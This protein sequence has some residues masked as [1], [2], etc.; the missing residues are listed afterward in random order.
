MK[1]L[2]K[3]ARLCS[4]ITVLG[5]L[6]GAAL[7]VAAAE[8]D[9]L[10]YTGAVQSNEAPSA[11]FSGFNS[12]VVTVGVRGSYYANIQEALDRINAIRLEACREGVRNPANPSRN[13]TINDYRPLK[14]SATLEKVARQRAAEASLRRGHVRPDGRS[15]E[16]ADI[17]NLTSS[18]ELIAWSSS[19]NLVDN[20]NLFYDEKNAWVYQTG[21]KSGHYAGLI[22]PNNTYVGLGGFY[23]PEC[24]SY[25]GSMCARLTYATDAGSTSYGQPTDTVMVSIR[26]LSSYLST[27]KISESSD[28]SDKL[29]LGSSKVYDMWSST[30]IDEMSG[31]VFFIDSLSWSS[32]NTDVARV[33]GGR[34]TTLSMGKAT[35]TAASTTGVSASLYLEVTPPDVSVTLNKSKLNLEPGQSFQL[36]TTL[37]P[38]N[39]P[40]NSITWKNSDSTVVSLTSDGKVTAKKA[41]TA[42]ITAKAM[43]GDTAKCTVVVT[44]PP[45]SITLDKTSKVLGVG[46]T[47]QL[48]ATLPSDSTPGIT[49]TTGNSSVVTVSNGKLT[50]KGVGTTTVTA[51]TTNGKTAVCNVEVKAAPPALLMSYSTKPI[52]LGETF[53]LTASVP[54]GCASDSITW[55][56]NNSKVVSVTNGKIKGLQLGSATITAKTYNGR[57][58]T[59][60]VRVREAPTSLSLDASSKKIGV[61]EKVTLTAILNKSEASGKI[62]WTSADKSVVTVSGGVV[63]GVGEGTAVV[64]AATFN[65]KTARCTVTVKSAPSSIALNKSSATLGV[66]EGL[67]LKATLSSGSASDSIVWSSSD[68]SVAAVENGNVTPLKAGTAVISAKTYNGKIARCSITVKNAPEE[69]TLSESKIILG[70]GEAASLDYSIPQDSA[71]AVRWITSNS[72]TASVNGGRITA[73][74]EGTAT[75]T[76]KTYNGKKASCGIVVRSAPEELTI[77]ETS[78]TVGMGEIRELSAAVNKGSASAITWSSSNS[79][80]ASVNNGLVFSI[81]TGTVTITAETYNGLKASCTIEVVSAPEEITLSRNSLVLGMGE[82]YTLEATIPEGSASE[83]R[84]TSSNENVVTVKDGKITTVGEGT[85]D[86]TVTAF[87]G[88]SDSCSITVR[89]APEWITL[90]HEKIYLGVGET[91]LLCAQIPEESASAITWKTSNPDIAEVEDGYVRA[92]TE[93]VATVTVKTYNGQVARCTVVVRSAPQSI[94]LSEE[95]KDI[96]EGEVYTLTASVPK[97]TASASIEWI[98][99]DESVASVENGVVTGLGVGTAVIG[100]RTYNGMMDRCVINVKA[101]PQSFELSEQKIIIGEGESFLLDTVFAEGTASGTVKWTSSTKKTAS[102]TDGLVQ[103]MSTGT[104]RITVT[105]YNGIKSTCSVI[106]RA[107]PEEVSLDTDKIYIGVGESYKLTATLPKGSISAL[108]WRAGNIDIASVENGTI[109]GNTE[110]VTTVTVKTFNGMEARCT[111]VVRAEPYEISLNETKKTLGVGESVTLRAELPKGTASAGLR[112][113]SGN[114]SV[115]KVLSDG[116]VQAVGTGSTVIAVRTYNGLRAALKLTVR[117]APQSITLNRTKK[118]LGIGEKYQLKTTLSKGSASDTIIWESS[119]NEVVTVENGMLTAVGNGTAVVSAATFNGMTATCKVIVKNAP[120]YVALDNEE[121]TLYEGETATLKASVT[122]GSFSAYIWSVGN[123]AIASVSNGTVKALSAGRTR[124][125]VKTYNGL[126]TT[127]LVIV[128]AAA[129]DTSTQ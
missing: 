7:S 9:P 38:K 23:S 42:V 124:V 32:S 11:S 1:I 79:R 12:T 107:A 21:E 114:I 57:T 118:Y 49:W 76:V 71:S 95:R 84:W 103:G 50:A 45:S 72:E 127:C 87:N 40:Y 20:I 8:Y 86:I 112:W 108:T 97:N 70:V 55:S 60:S 43:S 75:I 13:L 81:R 119:N 34:V 123:P 105:T 53:T 89:S 46:E 19:Q 111:V 14:W 66:G 4:V 31:R 93:G 10:D 25:G 59:C 117:S 65:G 92:N 74:K 96:G 121:I 98:S 99:T 82:K 78:L 2:K 30:Q 27:P 88:V 41:G 85:A 90:D 69:I 102:V 94:E 120:D 115:A 52:G 62:T 6:G 126:S 36:K 116:T 110:G 101:A 29:H 73:L 22:D 15:C 91:F 68:D 24:C 128:K 16:T 48:T 37:V 35:I 100:V 33:S 129:A 5:I 18:Y 44:N 64:T 3:L 28:N 51:T 54:D 109:T 106:V 77:S 83:L 80:V 47:A 26:V 58:A 67:E 61:G 125:T 63:K 39:T 56:S 104:T 113:T 122:A 17:N